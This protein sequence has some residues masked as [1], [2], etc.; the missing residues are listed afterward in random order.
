MVARRQQHLA[1]AVLRFFGFGCRVAVIASRLIC[2]LRTVVI[3]RCHQTFALSILRFL[4]HAIC[5]N[6]E[7]PCRCAVVVTRRKHRF[8]L[9]VLCFFGFGCR[10]AVIASRLECRNGFV[11]LPVLH[12]LDRCSIL[13]ARNNHQFSNRR[14]CDN[15][16]NRSQRNHLV[17]PASFHFL[18]LLVQPFL[19]ELFALLRLFPAVLVIAQ[20]LEPMSNSRI[21]ILRFRPIHSIAAV[22]I[23]GFKLLIPLLNRALL[24]FRRFCVRLVKRLRQLLLR[25]ADI[26]RLLR[27]SLL[28]PLVQFS[29]QRS[30]HP[31]IPRFHLALRKLHRTDKIL[32]LALLPHPIQIIFFIVHIGSI[33]LFFWIK[34]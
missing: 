34:L 24:H 5:F 9:L 22:L 20:C 19:S 31:F 8:A 30:H 14:N 13:N 32:I 3:S 6:R 23:F 7:I 10:V 15:R 1:F 28:Q 29:V 11:I 21:L 18:R 2:Q 33:R 16:R 12:H 4:R 17:A 26:L 27:P 25:L